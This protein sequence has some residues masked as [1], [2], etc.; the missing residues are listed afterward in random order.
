MNGL[1]LNP[2]SK[3]RLIV[4]VFILFT[5][6]MIPSITPLHA[7][8]SSTSGMITVIN[9]LGTPPGSPVVFDANGDGTPDFSITYLAVGAFQNISITGLDGN[10]IYTTMIGAVTGADDLIGTPINEPVCSDGNFQLSTTLY[11]LSQGVGTI[12][13]GAGGAYMGFTNDNGTPGDPSDDLYGFINIDIATPLTST[14]VDISFSNFALGPGMLLPIGDCSV[15]MPVL[16][17]SAGDC[18]SVVPVELSI[19]EAK[20][21]NE[22]KDI[23][24]RWVTETELD[25]DGFYLERSFDG[26]KFEIIHWTNGY[27]TS[28]EPHEYTFK[29]LKLPIA[30]NYYYRLQQVDT[31]GSIE[32]S[33]LIQVGR[34]KDITVV[35]RVYPNPVNSEAWIDIEANEMIDAKL[36]LYDTAGNLQSNIEVELNKGNNT[37]KLPIVS[38]DSKLLFAKVQVDNTIIHRKL[39][40]VNK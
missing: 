25:N 40:L 29:D 23:E 4:V 33:D 16:G 15:S 12:F 8:C 24:I 28:I 34:K 21:I 26:K 6:L 31:D 36:W 30:A 13:G 2:I 11:N 14:S 18:S 32:Y 39:M 20:Y 10:T 9:S 1:Y 27:G 38:F 19:F 5:L 37:I 17:V 35:G 7:Q 3:L 22:S